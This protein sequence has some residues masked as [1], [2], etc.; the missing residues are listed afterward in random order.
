[1]IPCPLLTIIPREVPRD[2]DI[3]AS[4]VPP[5]VYQ[6]GLDFDGWERQVVTANNEV[7]RRHAAQVV[8]NQWEARISICVVEALQMEAVQCRHH[9]KQHSCPT[10][11]PEHDLLTSTLDSIIFLNELFRFCC[12]LSF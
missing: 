8:I 9:S 6:I 12:S 7:R 11:L 5:G 10:L 4:S 3:V 1:M 2:S